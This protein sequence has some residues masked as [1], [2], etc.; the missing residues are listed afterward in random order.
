VGDTTATPASPDND[1]PEPEAESA[2][3]PGIKRYRD[4]L[5]SLPERLSCSLSVP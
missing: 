5:L 3:L 1:V 4:S 2:V